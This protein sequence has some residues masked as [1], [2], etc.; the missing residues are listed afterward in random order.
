MMKLMTAILSCIVAYFI[1]E[2]PT[3]AAQPEFLGKWI[4]EQGTC[5]SAK[6]SNKLSYGTFEF[7]PGHRYHFEGVCNVKSQKKIGKS[8]ELDEECNGGVEAHK[9]THMHW[10]IIVDGDKM[11]AIITRPGSKSEMPF[12]LD[13]CTRKNIQAAAI[14]KAPSVR[15]GM[16][17]TRARDIALK[18]GFFAPVLPSYGYSKEDK[19][20]AAECDGNI[21]L[22]NKYPEIDSCGSGHCKMTFTDAYGNTF[23]ILTYGDIS[24]GTASVTSA[25]ISCKK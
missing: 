3:S 23:A 24:D 17:Y 4:D 6:N 18:S 9:I 14:C 10:S 25:E 1:L 16:P 15:Q 12:T 20:V 5:E 19:K 22:C 8:W 7:T 21:A 11:T 2:Y 13:R